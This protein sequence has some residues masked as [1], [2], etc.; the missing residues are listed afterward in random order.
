MWL[1]SLNTGNVCQYA[2]YEEN[3]LLILIKI[4]LKALSVILNDSFVKYHYLSVCVAVTV[5]LF[6]LWRSWSFIEAVLRQNCLL[7]KIDN[8]K[9]KLDLSNKAL[10]FVDVL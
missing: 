3:L 4:Y 10:T 7:N 8:N 1:L 6:S 9:L 2:L 5:Y